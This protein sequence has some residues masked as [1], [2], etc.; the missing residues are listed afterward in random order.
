MTA[1]IQQTLRHD[2]SLS[3]LRNHFSMCLKPT[4]FNGSAYM[5]KVKNGDKHFSGSGQ[6]AQPFQIL[7]YLWVS[8]SQRFTFTDVP[9]VFQN[10][11]MKVNWDTTLL[12]FD[13][14]YISSA[15]SAQ[16]LIQHNFIVSHGY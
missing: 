4:E 16:C 14:S 1:L 13:K 7:K 5:H 6:T 11:L 9:A 3:L 8:F 10:F 12:I 15:V 2:K